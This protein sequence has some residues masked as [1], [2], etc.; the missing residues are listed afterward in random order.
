MVCIDVMWCEKDIVV[1]C[2][3]IEKVFIQKLASM[4]TEVINS[5]VLWRVS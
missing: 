3:S 1:M 4:P 2:Q 5:A